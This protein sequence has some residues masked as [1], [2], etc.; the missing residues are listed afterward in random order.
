MNDNK[1]KTVLSK[2]AQIGNL[3]ISINEFGIVQIAIAQNGLG[4]MLCYFS[5]QVAS[6]VLANGLDLIQTFEPTM[7][8]CHGCL[9]EIKLPAPFEMNGRYLCKDCTP[10]NHGGISDVNV[11][12]F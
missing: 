1:F 6:E 2:Q 12:L 7:V 4:Q 11:E 10:P 8:I 5:Q 9:T 3:S